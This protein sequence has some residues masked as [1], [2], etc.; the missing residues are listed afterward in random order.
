[1]EKVVASMTERLLAKFVAPEVLSKTG[2]CSISFIYCI[3]IALAVY[4]VT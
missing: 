3:A 1:M 2:K 4:G